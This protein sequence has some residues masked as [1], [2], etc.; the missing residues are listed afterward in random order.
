M[1]VIAR[2]TEFLR[3]RMREMYP[4]LGVPL[5]RSPLGVDED[6]AKVEGLA[7]LLTEA[8]KKSTK[9]GGALDPREVA[10][11]VAWKMVERGG[12]PLAETM[13]CVDALEAVLRD[14]VEA[15]TKRGK[16]DTRKCAADML[17]RMAA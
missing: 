3:D 2:P 6:F 11:Y 8:I 12:A 17:R 9:A 16:L 15:T 14:S 13:K 5:S 10:A 4:K 7:C 1:T